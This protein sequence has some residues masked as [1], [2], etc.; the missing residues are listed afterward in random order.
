MD[1]PARAL[2]LALIR[3]RT[4][5]SYEETWL[6]QG[7]AADAN[8]NVAPFAR[9]DAVRFSVLGAVMRAGRGS[10]DIFAGA[11][12]IFE[13]VSP[14]LF[15]KL[16]TR[17]VGLTHLE[18]LALLDDAI[19]TLMPGHKSGIMSAVRLTPA[20]ITRVGRRVR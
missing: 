4:L 14:E 2:A 5:I 1:R 3:A 13:Q 11:R 9:E 20:T 6:A 8:G 17:G 15:G 19:R 7:Y 10:I 12:A 18:A 16:V